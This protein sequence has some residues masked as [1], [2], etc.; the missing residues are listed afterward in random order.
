MLAFLYQMLMVAGAL[1][2]YEKHCMCLA[3]FFDMAVEAATRQS[4]SEKYQL[5]FSCL[6]INR[7]HSNLF[8]HGIVRERSKNDKQLT[9]TNSPHHEPN[10]HFAIHP[11]CYIVS[12]SNVF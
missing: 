7:L 3:F 9:N 2:V 5:S 11:V 8:V 10:E 1:A 4:A 6:L 12:S